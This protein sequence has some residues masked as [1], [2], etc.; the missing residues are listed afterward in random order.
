MQQKFL[1]NFVWCLL[2]LMVDCVNG[3][4]NGALS[5]Q[6]FTPGVVWNDTQGHRINAHGGGV[7]FHGGRYFWFGEHKLPGRSEAQKAD[8]GV[9][10]YSSTNLYDWKDEGLALAVNRTNTQS[11]I[12]AGC[13]LERPKVLFNAATR[14]FVMFFKLY[15]V[16]TGYD[17]GYVGV[18]TATNAAGPYVY[19]H[20]FVGGGSPK[21]T[22]DFAL[23]QGSDGEMYHLAVRKPDKAFCAARLRS[24]Y[25]FPEGDYQIVEG[26]A[27]HTEAPTVVRTAAGYYLLGSG[28]SSWK[29]NAAR[30][31]FSTNLTG[32]YEPL[33][34]PVAGVNPHNGLGPEKTFGGQISFVISVTGKTNAYIALFDQWKPETPINGGYIWLPLTIESGKPAVQWRDTWNLSVFDDK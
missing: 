17:T 33:G 10:C 12:A 16:G 15:P 9:H 3:Q 11:E 30:A 28:S 2:P 19:R 31:F 13:I 32:P 5:K 18:A 29:P 23:V 22:G 1:R 25:L 34:N 26:I 14:T 4:T 21:G 24:D 20:R 6:R 8:G 27:Q 7:I